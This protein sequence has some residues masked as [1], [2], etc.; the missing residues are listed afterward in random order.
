MTPDHDF[1]MDELPGG[2]VW[3]CSACSGHGFKFA[4]LVGAAMADLVQT[5][6]TERMDVAKFA[7]ERL[8]RKPQARL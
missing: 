1:V 2:R 4:P 3:L 5:G 8:L 6:T 7:L